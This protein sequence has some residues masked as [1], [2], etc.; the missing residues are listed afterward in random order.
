LAAASWKI[1]DERAG[2]ASRQKTEATWSADHPIGVNC[3]A[4]RR[5]TPNQ[6]SALQQRTFCA[7]HYL[8]CDAK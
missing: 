7:C 8:L 2:N 1:L 5:N 4:F 6:S 3:M